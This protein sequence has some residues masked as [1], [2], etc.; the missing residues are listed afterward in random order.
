MR[1]WVSLKDGL[2]LNGLYLCLFYSGIMEVMQFF[3]GHWTD[4]RGGMED[5]ITHWMPLPEPPNA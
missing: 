1:E 4:Y 3:D 2:P 5:W